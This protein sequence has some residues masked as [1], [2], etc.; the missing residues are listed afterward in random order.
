[1]QARIVQVGLGVRGAQ[2]AK[3]IKETPHAEIVAFVARNQERLRK[4]ARELGFDGTPCFADLSS[5]LRRVQADIL[6]LVSPPQ[7][8]YEQAMLGFEHGLHVLAEKP[9]VENLK[10]AVELVQEAE[11]RELLLGVSMNFRY[12]ATSQKIR[13]ILSKGKLGTCSFSQFTYIRHR[14]PDRSDLNDYPKFMEHPMLVE[15]SIHHFDLMRYCFQ[16]DV[17][18]VQ[19]ATWNPSWSTYRANSNVAAILKFTRGIYVSYLGTWISGSNRLEFKWRIDCSGGTLVQKRQFEDLRVSQFVEELSLTGPNFKEEDTVEPLIPVEIPQVKPFIDD[20]R[21][22]LKKFLLS[23]RDRTPF[24]TDGA[25][26]VRTLSVVLACIEAA[27]TGKRVYMQ[28]FYDQHNI[29]AYLRG[30]NG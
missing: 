28:E 5:A 29:P 19:A 6:V 13:E 25:D 7:V 18:W 2:W 11:R 21:T 17:E 20:T 15:Q 16:D 22:L 23:V 27:E 1:M 4:R 14:N 8:H 3:V 12:L 30:L 26:H 24:E 9:L 10:E